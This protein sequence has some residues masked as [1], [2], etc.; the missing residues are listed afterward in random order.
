MTKDFLSRSLWHLVRKIEELVN[1][2]SSSESYCNVF[3]VLAVHSFY[4]DTRFDLLAKLCFRMQICDK[5]SK[6]TAYWRW[7]SQSP[8]KWTAQEITSITDPD[9]FTSGSHEHQPAKYISFLVLLQLIKPIFDI[10]DKGQALKNKGIRSYSLYL[11]H[12]FIINNW[13]AYL[14]NTK[15]LWKYPVMSIP[16]LSTVCK[17]HK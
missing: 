17:C 14:N 7:R 11:S 8:Q 15:W 16:S 2:F 10:S 4:C 5:V 1:D 6:S 12:S 13:R 9:S 3:K